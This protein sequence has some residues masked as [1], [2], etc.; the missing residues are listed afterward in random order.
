MPL[1]HLCATTDR[2]N[3]NSMSTDLFRAALPATPD[4]SF[5]A[6]A[7]QWVGVYLG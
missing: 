3:A 7:N 1:P 6:D 5:D 4:L 2:Q